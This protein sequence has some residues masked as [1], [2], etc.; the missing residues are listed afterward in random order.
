MSSSNQHEAA[1]LPEEVEIPITDSLDLHLFRPA[2][3]GSL[4]PEYLAECRKRGILSVR[5]IHG[6][7]IG[8]QRER[9]HR[10]LTE[11]DFVRD[12]SLAGTTSGGWGATWAYLNPLLS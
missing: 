1:D 4:I 11:L 7:G 5:I 9:V 8:T 10:I 12:F 6:K 3:L 2:D